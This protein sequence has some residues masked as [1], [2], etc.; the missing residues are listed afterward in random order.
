MLMSPVNEAYPPEALAVSERVADP[1]AL[2]S[3][4][5]RFVSGVTVITCRSGNTTHGMTANSFISVSLD[6]ARALVSVRKAARMHALLSGADVF[7][8]SVLSADHSAVSAH[9]AGAPDAD[10]EPQFNERCGVPVIASSI[11]WMVCR[12]DSVVAIGD[13]SLFIGELIDCDHDPFADP[14]VYFGGRYGK[15]AG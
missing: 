1:K 2:R 10:F 8:L 13:H 3:T 15:L 11:A 6:P 4:F 9:F 12:R 14:L 5:G 7:G